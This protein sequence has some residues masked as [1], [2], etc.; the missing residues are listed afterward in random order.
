[1]RDELEKYILAHK[2]EFDTERPDSKLWDRIYRDLIDEEQP[3]PEHQKSQPKSERRQFSIW[4]I[5]AVIAVLASIGFTFTWKSMQPETVN[6]VIVEQS[7]TPLNEMEAYYQNA[8]RVRQEQ[9][10][11]FEDIGVQPDQALFGQLGRLQE[12]YLELRHEL[13]SSQDQDVVVDAM[14]KN[15]MMQMEILNQ[16]LMILEQIKSMKDEKDTQL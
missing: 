2:R 11:S 13:P 15:L 5:A 12:L 3:G 9:I 8:I 1:M 4:K 7:E 6:Q 16:Q 14:V 10:R